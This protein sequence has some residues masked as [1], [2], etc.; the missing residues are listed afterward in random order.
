ML[1]AAKAQNEGRGQ[2][3]T[4]DL[5]AYRDD[6]L[7]L[8]TRPSSWDGYAY[9]ALRGMARAEAE[10]AARAKNRGSSPLKGGHG[11]ECPAKGAPSST[12][13]PSVRQRTQQRSLHYLQSKDVS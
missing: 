9:E 12:F 6:R 5:T 3:Y 11:F 13:V 2:L 7:G 10:A 4:G 1:G 8:V